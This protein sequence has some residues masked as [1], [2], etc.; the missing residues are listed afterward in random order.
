MA[1]W[2]YGNQ[3]WAAIGTPTDI[4]GPATAI[5]ADN[6]D[7][8]KIF[9]AGQTL[10]GL[11]YLYYWNG[12]TWSDINNG[13]LQSGSG[14]EQL[15]F[16]PL[17]SDHSSNSIIESNRMLLVSGDLNINDTS[18]SSA[19]FDGHSWYPYLISTSNSGTG[20]V[21]SQF[22]YSIANFQLSPGRE[23]Y[24]TLLYYR[25]SLLT[26]LFL[27][28]DYLS[29]GI[30]ILISIAIGLGLVFLLV[31]IG[32][33]IALSRRH[34]EPAY[35]VQELNDTDSLYAQRQPNDLLGTVAAATAVLLDGKGGGEKSASPD[36]GAYGDQLFD[37]D[38]AARA[39]FSFVGE[40]PGELSIKAGE[41][42]LVLE[43]S[44][45]NWYVFFLSFC[46]LV[47]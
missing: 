13:T 1:Q 21:I 24:H 8:S 18:I 23:F 14:I 39:R 26:F 34:D 5:S 12:T 37:G 28:T 20:G 35:P 41:D 46:R 17:L 30:V 38:S 36:S 19:L 33:L 6:S 42:L 43:A 22:F 9:A 31:L 4:P 2:S 11:P 47:V 16:V 10:T 44:D 45:V 15:L 40:H 32:L 29:V 3:S 7:E 27:S 25:I